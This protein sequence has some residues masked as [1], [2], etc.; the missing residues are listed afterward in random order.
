MVYLFQYSHTFVVCDWWKKNSKLKADFY[1]NLT[2]YKVIN[3][4]H[5]AAFLK[6]F[7]FL[8]LYI[9]TNNLTTLNV[10]PCRASIQVVISFIP[11][12]FKNV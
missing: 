6:H 7:N 2:P 5:Q 11:E 12:K 10:D 4:N 8:T 1:Q 9:Y 3:T